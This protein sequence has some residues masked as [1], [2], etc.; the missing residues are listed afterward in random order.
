MNERRSGSKR[1]TL[2]ETQGLGLKMSQGYAN[3]DI[4]NKAHCLIYMSAETDSAIGLRHPRF[5]LK[6]A[7]GARFGKDGASENAVVQD[8]TS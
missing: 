5:N 6:R 7:R 1:E 4:L 3:A 2:R 8:G